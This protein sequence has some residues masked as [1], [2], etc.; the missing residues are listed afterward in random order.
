MK[1]LL[2]LICCIPVVAG[3]QQQTPGNDKSVVRTQITGQ[4]ELG[5]QL[6]MHHCAPCHGKQAHGGIAGPDL[7][8]SRYKYGKSRSI[9][10]K[11]I[12][13]GRAGGMP[14][15]GSQLKPEEIEALADYLTSVNQK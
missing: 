2:F 3:C 6:F 15:F 8:A 7:T 10:I 9:I 12:T 14:T 13:D 11:T 5:Q 4:K 1:R